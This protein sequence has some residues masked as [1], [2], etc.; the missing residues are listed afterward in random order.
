MKEREKVGRPS[1]QALDVWLSDEIAPKDPHPL[2][3]MMLLNEIESL[4]REIVRLEEGR[5]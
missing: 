5:K 4:K 3:V 1:R 2:L